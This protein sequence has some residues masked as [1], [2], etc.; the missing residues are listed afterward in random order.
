MKKGVKP[1]IILPYSHVI[2]KGDIVIPISQSG[3]TAWRYKRLRYGF[4]GN[5]LD[6]KKSNSLE[7][8]FLL[9]IIINT[10]YSPFVGGSIVESY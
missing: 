6:Q 9:N 5:A 7:L 4:D 10:F 2:N 1:P 8:L 3:E